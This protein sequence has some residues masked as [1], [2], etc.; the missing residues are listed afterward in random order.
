MLLFLLFLPST[1]G[2]E[3]EIRNFEYS[4]YTDTNI[5]ELHYE[6]RIDESE[7]REGN[8]FQIPGTS[9]EF[10]K[11]GVRYIPIHGPDVRK[12]SFETTIQ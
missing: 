3:V 2:V 1:S 9:V 8:S 12:V 7:W 10:V 5:D 11:K 6:Y 4:Y